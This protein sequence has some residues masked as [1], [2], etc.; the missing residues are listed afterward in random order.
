ME[1]LKVHVKDVIEGLELVCNDLYK[2]EQRKAYDK[3][4]IV[5]GDLTEVINEIGLIEGF[6][7]DKLMNNLAQALN[8][9]EELDYILLS[10]ILK[11]EIVEQLTAIL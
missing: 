7:L 11:Y 5:L 6:D 8:A 2:Q 1:D 4:N 9:M 10:D 3:L